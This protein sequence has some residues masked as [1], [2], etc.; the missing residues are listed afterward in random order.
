[1]TDSNREPRPARQR[2]RRGRAR[3]RHAGE[4]E[5][6]PLHQRSTSH[7]E[8]ADRARGERYFSQGRVT[9]E[10]E[11]ARARAWVRGKERR[12]Y[13][14][15]LDWSR[16]E[17]GRRLHVFCECERFAGGTFCKHVW[18]TMLALQAQRPE[19][20]PVGKDR[21]GVRQDNAGDW[22]DLVPA[23]ERTRGNERPGRKRV[24]RPRPGRRV[25]APAARSWRAHF[26][27]IQGEVAKLSHNQRA[28]PDRAPQRDLQL[29]VDAPSSVTAGGLVL[30]VFESRGA[31]AGRPGPLRPVALD[32]AQL[33]DLVRSLE[34]RPINGAAEPAAASSDEPTGETEENGV[35]T[36]IAA[37]PGDAAG[38]GPGRDRGKRPVPRG[39]PR[40][41]RTELGRFSRLRLPARLYDTMLPRLCDLGMLRL[42]DGNGGGNPRPLRW[43]EG[44][45]WHLALRLELAAADRM[46]LRGMLER[47]G[48]RVPLSRPPLVLPNLS[49]VHAAG[50]PAAAEDGDGRDRRNGAQ[51]SPGLVFFGDSVGR[52]D[53]TR[54]SELPWIAL[55]REEGE[56]V[57]EAE[58]LEEAITTLFELPDLPPLQVPEGFRLQREESPPQPRLVLEPEDTPEWMNP[59]LLADVS[60]HYGDLTVGAGDQRPVVTDLETGRIARRDLDRERTALV[61]LLELGFKPSAGGH[62]D[63]L[64]LDP[65]Q[66]P[67]VAEALLL[68]GWE[69][70]ARGVSMRAPSPPSLRVKSGVDWFE[71]SGHVEFAGDRVDLSRVLEAISKG[72][73]SLQLEDGSRG[74]VPSSWI[75]TYGPLS[76]LAQSAS[77]D[78]LRFLPSQALLVDALLVA[79]PPADVDRTFAELREKL[80]TF[81]RIKA[82]KEPRGFQ[83]TLRSYQRLGLG[84]LCFLREYGLG[85]IL[86]DDMGL[87]K[88]VQ[89]LAML[90]TYRA[91]SKSSGLPYLVVAPRSLI[92]NWIEEA[93]RFTPGLTVVEYGGPDRDELQ[94]KLGEYD[95]VVTTYG[96]LRRD[97]A[98]LA[99]Q[100]FDTVIL[101]EAQAIKNPESQT[102]KAARLLH[103]RHRLALTG[104]PIENHLGELGSIFEF[105]NP[106]LLGR[107]P[108]LDVLA[109]GREAS[110]EE[111]RLVA[112]GIRPFIL[113]RTK[114]EVLAD[115]P[116]KTEQVLHCSLRPEQRE[117]YDQLLATYRESLLHDVESTGIGGSTMKVLE[118]LLRLRQV[119][120]HPGLVDP[121]WASAGSAKLEAL[122]EQVAEVLAEGH[123]AVVFSQ[124]TKLLAYVREKLDADGVPYAYLDGQ[125]RDRG[126]VVEHFQTDPECNLFLISLKAGGVGLNLTAASYVFLLDPWWNPAVEAQAIDRTHRIGQTHPVFAYR[127]I[128][129]D[130]VEA[131]MLDLQA[132]KRQ[133]ADA[134]LD[135][136]GEAVRELTVDDL[137]LLLS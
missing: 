38:D 132:S 47:D 9:L 119:A 130:T 75:D 70:T 32:L 67:L 122:F 92:Y 44:A 95:L 65:R 74:L 120:C 13:G 89:A 11:G 6:A 105:L 5:R 135:G 85:G 25:P 51:A 104:T 114:G 16:V 31:A 41:Q 58:E 20:Q 118:A 110:K 86:A 59:Q 12:T 124:F 21:L 81:D 109:G 106:G 49:G 8:A 42:R 14:V 127:L 111:L 84:W 129:H 103:A 27:W 17:T 128:A 62:G 61:R 78:G 34:Q 50:E 24:D 77:E 7:F 125:T 126:Q 64:E 35:L 54:P 26:D 97:I 93:K 36:V 91:A 79:M 45:P 29:V 87:G 56:I 115:L 43:D 48:E 33:E 57:F 90:K 83:G 69:V 107:L 53:V 46:R 22:R 10:V 137:K 40:T 63:G 98:F 134:I 18:A 121:A 73:R 112:K 108:A 101:D 136:E 94:N 23:A 39:A 113:R 52:L 15:G 4:G 99:S 117:L 76:Q 60:F 19:A 55:L 71:L 80:Q 30:D 68:E 72:E 123:K 28:T 96:T 100:E 2:R 133:L 116:E 131:R 88:T 1:M 82:K 102:A 3:T 66:L 37:L